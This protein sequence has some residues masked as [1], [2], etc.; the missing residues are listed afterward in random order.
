MAAQPRANTRK[1]SVPT[2]TPILSRTPVLDNRPLGRRAVAYC[3]VVAGNMIAAAARDRKGGRGYVL[4]AFANLG[5]QLRMMNVWSRYAS[6]SDTYDVVCNEPTAEAFS[7][8]AGV[9]YVREYAAQ[10]AY[11]LMGSLR[12]AWTTE[13]QYARAFVPH[14]FFTRPIA[15]AYARTHASTVIAIAGRGAT[16]GTTVELDASSWRATYEGIAAACH[17]NAI[18]AHAPRLAPGFARARAGSRRVVVHV[19]SSEE[20]RALDAVADFAIVKGLLKLGLRV[21]VTGA[22]REEAKLRSILKDLDISF[23]CGAPLRKVTQLLCASDLFLGVDSSVMHLADAVG[24]PCVI[25]YTSTRSDVAGPFY[26]P[27][28]AIE[29]SHAYEPVGVRPEQSWRVSSSAAQHISVEAVVEASQR[30]LGYS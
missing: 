22:A 9:R 17:P 24:L 29:P 15:L 8:Y 25:V 12:N 3:A 2:N 13:G 18:A 30:A 11:S 4:V 6:A 26:A 19:V 1:G 10:G 20:S 28:V 27:F 5:D 21:V 14:P 23:M 16:V 7:L